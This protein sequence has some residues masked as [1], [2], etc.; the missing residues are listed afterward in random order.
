M[1]KTAAM[2]SLQMI[3]TVIH[4]CRAQLAALW[5]LLAR[6]IGPLREYANH[7]QPLVAAL[8]EQRF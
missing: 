5:R 6:Q 7:C 3:V 1:Q 2:A 8:S 4:R